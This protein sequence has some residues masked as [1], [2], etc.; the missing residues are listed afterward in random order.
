MLKRDRES[1]LKHSQI[2]ME[3]I[4]ILGF[5]MIVIIGILGTALFY[6]GSIKDRIKIIQVNNFANKIIT[7][8]ESVYYYGEPSKST[9]SVYLPE[10]VKEIT[11]SQNNLFITTQ[12]S[13]GLEKSSFSSEV[14][15]DG[16]ISTSSGIKK[17][18]IRAEV[19]KTAI[20]SV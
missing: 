10:G 19:N 1:K 7:T 18:V 17:I 15:I 6:S 4:I 2:S 8:A 5:V 14:P 11:I 3:Y 9:I 16:V 13:S 20:N 12:V